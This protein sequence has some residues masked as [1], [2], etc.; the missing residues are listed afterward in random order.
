VLRDQDAWPSS[1]VALARE[2]L[3]ISPS[4]WP[5]RFD[6]AAGRCGSGFSVANL[7]ASTPIP[8]PLR[9]LVMLGRESDKPMCQEWV[10]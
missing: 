7:A 5:R 3:S 6:D 4:A 2:I 9:I 8:P 1:L 10:D